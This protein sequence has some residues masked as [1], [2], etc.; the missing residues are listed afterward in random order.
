MI[1]MYIQLNNVFANVERSKKIDIFIGLFLHTEA[2][3]YGKYYYSSI[4]CLGINMRDIFI[5][6][7]MGFKDMLKPILTEFISAL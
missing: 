5:I 2:T 7:I 3:L 1:N 6:S 4:A